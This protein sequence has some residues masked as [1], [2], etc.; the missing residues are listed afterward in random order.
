MDN[1]WLHLALVSFIG[2]IIGDFALMLLVPFAGAGA[3][4]PSAMIGTMPS[5]INMSGMMSGTVMPGM[6][7]GV[8]MNMSTPMVQIGFTDIQRQLTDIKTMMSIGLPTAVALGLI[9]FWRSFR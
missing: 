9:N 5:G 3:M 4:N 1:K 2:I 7:M 8:N 6:P